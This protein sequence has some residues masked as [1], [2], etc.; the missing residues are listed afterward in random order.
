MATF[1]VS[2]D[3]RFAT[4]A[5]WTENY[6]WQGASAELAATPTGKAVNDR[7][8]FLHASCSLQKIRAQAVPHNRN[9]FVKSIGLSGLRNPGGAVPGPDE[10]NTSALCQLKSTANNSQRHIWFRGLADLDVA[11][12]P[13]SGVSEPSAFLSARLTT[14]LADIATQ[15]YYIQSNTPLGASPY[16]YQTAV[17]VTGVVGAGMATITFIGTSQAAIGQRIVLGQF[18]PKLF[19]GLNGTWTVLAQAANTFTI[20]YNLD[21]LPPATVV[22]GRWR[23]YMPLYGVISFAASDFLTFSTRNTGLGF[24][25]GRGRRRAVRLRSL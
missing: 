24:S 22:K 23:P 14:F 9:V 7:I 5:G 21:Y 3:F 19:P 2:W 10:A 11:L 4:G 1:F 25:V 18:S 12:N 15:P 13:T 6:Y 16:I 8:A 17:S 20:A